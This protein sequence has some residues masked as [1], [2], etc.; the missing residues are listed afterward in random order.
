MLTNFAFI[1]TD[2][3]FTIHNNVYVIGVDAGDGSA[4]QQCEKNDKNQ[5]VAHANVPLMR[6]V[7]VAKTLCNRNECDLTIPKKGLRFW[8]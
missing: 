7:I 6:E 2:D 1:Q 3:H 5:Y 4:Q 8:R